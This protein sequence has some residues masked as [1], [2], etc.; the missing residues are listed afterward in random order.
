MHA[1][2]HKIAENNDKDILQLINQIEAICK[3]VIKSETIL[4]M[5]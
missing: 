5:P 1:K 4:L 3:E 2:W